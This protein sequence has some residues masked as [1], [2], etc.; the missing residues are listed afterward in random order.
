[1]SQVQAHRVARRGYLLGLALA[2][3]GAVF[4]S[5]KAIIGKLLYVEGIDA[6]EG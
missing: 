1:M 2:I 6:L 3:V 5:G 4:F